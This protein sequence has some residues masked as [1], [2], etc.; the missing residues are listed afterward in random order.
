MERGGSVAERP[1]DLQEAKSAFL[2]FLAS[3]AAGK[4]LEKEEEGDGGEAARLRSAYIQSDLEATRDIMRRERHV[5]TLAHVLRSDKKDFSKLLAKLNEL[6]DSKGNVRPPSVTHTHTPSAIAHRPPSQHPSSSSFATPTRPP[7]LHSLS[8]P[9]PPPPFRPIIIVPSAI[10]A[11]LTL[12]NVADFLEREVWVSPIEKK[13]AGARKEKSILIHRT[14]REGGP[15]VCFQVIDNAATLRSGDWK[16]VVCVFASGQQWQ[17]K[18]WEWEAPVDLFANVLG[19]FLTFDDEKIPES[20]RGWDVKVISVNRRKRHLDKVAVS[21]FWDLVR[22][23]L[24]KL[25]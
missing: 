13:E 6:R 22:Q 12:L 19:L 14:L 8:L 25:C 10:T 11:M 4:T 17:F 1:R 18:G 15:N 5:R 23:R 24:K 7:S 3:A 2:Q 21:T 20:V 16:K 9:P